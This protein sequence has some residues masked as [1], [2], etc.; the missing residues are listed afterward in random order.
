[1]TKNDYIFCILVKFQPAVYY[2]IALLKYT[3]NDGMIRWHCCSVL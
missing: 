2:L 3:Q 1:L